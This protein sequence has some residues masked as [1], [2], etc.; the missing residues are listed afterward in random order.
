MVGAGWCEVNGALS[1]TQQFYVTLVET[2]WSSGRPEGVRAA[3]PGG[4][5][6]DESTLGWSQLLVPVFLPLASP[7]SH[8]WPTKNPLM[9]STQVTNY[10]VFLISPVSKLITHD[11]I[12]HYSWNGDDG[13]FVSLALEGQKQGTWCVSNREGKAQITEA[14]GLSPIFAYKIFHLEMVKIKSHCYILSFLLG[15]IW[16]LLGFY[17]VGYLL[18]KYFS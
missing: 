8:G 14:L 3:L 9:L 6:T 18:I 1:C 15:L 12:A 2:D 10:G 4:S 16:N 17:R 5:S 11:K 7:K 13:R